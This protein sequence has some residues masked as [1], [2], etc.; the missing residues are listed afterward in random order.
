MATPAHTAPLAQGKTCAPR[1]A[2]L[3]TLHY[4]HYM[5]TI[6]SE[7]GDQS[8]PNEQNRTGPWSASSCHPRS[9]SYLWCGQSGATWKDCHLFIYGK[10]APQ[11][12]NYR[13]CWPG[14]GKGLGAPRCEECM[15]LMGWVNISYEQKPCVRFVKIAPVTPSP[16]WPSRG[17]P[18]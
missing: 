7:K 18:P 4:I 16:S 11:T 10:T 8:D 3:H 5:H 1:T 17:Y 14:A 15:E 13:V 2:T 12:D 9:P 6:Q